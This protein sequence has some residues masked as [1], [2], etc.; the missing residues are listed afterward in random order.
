[1]DTKTRYKQLI[2]ENNDMLNKLG[3]SFRRIAYNYTKKAR[4]YGV[5]GIDTEVK[6][7]AVLEELTTYD[8]NHLDANIII[9]NMTEYIESHIKQLSKAPN[10]SIK[11]KEVLAVSALI[12]CIIGY[13]VLNSYLNRKRPLGVPTDAIVEV[14]STSDYFRLIWE[15]NPLASEGYTIKIYK[16]DGSMEPFT[17]IVKKNVD[18]NSGKQIS[19]IKEI[20]YDGVSRYVF[21]IQANE[22]ND[23]NE[24]EVFIVIY[25]S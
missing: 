14:D 15:E 7:K 22:T 24:S 1:M 21:E 17:K 23:Y 10:I 8:E 12:L 11:I 13:F 25:P 18:S 20:I 2:K 9:P 3:D 19:E 16:E 6:I 5:K 4:G